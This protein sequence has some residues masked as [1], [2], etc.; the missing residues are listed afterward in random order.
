MGRR[1]QI[2]ETATQLFISH[3][4]EHVSIDKINTACEIARGTFYIYFK[5]KDD[6]LTEILKVTLIEALDVTISRLPETS[7]SP[8]FEEEMGMIGR[9]VF[10]YFEERV[11]LVKL[12]VQS[13]IF[14]SMDIEFVRDLYSCFFVDRYSPY[15][16][17]IGIPEE[18][19][20][21]LLM[22]GFILLHAAVAY[23]F[24]QNPQR[25]QEC[26]NALIC[27]L[28]APVSSGYSGYC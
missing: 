6:L 5:N 23:V 13:R 17:S 16:L 27:Y 25:A 21:T 10:S 12:V 1:Q 26:K 18:E 28:R 4:Y 7:A 2:I 11:E 19:I 14:G 22:T 15:F 8:R 24:T 9:T 3:G 20:N